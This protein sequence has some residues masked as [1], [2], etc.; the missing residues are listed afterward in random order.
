MA[1]DS[2]D[3]GENSFIV[4]VWF[5]AWEGCDWL[6]TVWEDDGAAKAHYRFRYHSEEGDGDPFAGNDTKNWYFLTGPDRGRLVDACQNVASMTAST[7][8]AHI[9][10]HIEVL[11]SMQDMLEA[12][13]AFPWAHIRRVPLN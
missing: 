4:A 12:M 6:C 5:V 2:K 8:N 11:G 10:D 1:N 13:T 7:Q 3:P 9:N